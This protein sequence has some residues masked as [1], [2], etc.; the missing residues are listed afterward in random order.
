MMKPIIVVNFKTY[1][2][3]SGKKALKLASV[4]ERVAR[5]SKIIPVVQHADLG[6]VAKKIDLDVYAQHVDYFEPGRNT[7]FST[8][9]SLQNNKVKGSLLNHSEHKLKL[10]IVKKTVKRCKEKNFKVIVCVD[11]LRKTKKILKSQPEMLAFEVP[12]LISTGKS[13]TK[14]KGK[15]VTKFAQIVYK[16]NKKNK[17]KVIPLCG[18]GI[19]NEKDVKAAIKL[20]CSG[21]LVASAVVKSRNPA[22]LLRKMLL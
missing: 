6:F 17:T 18:A 7:G 1:E 13:I 8:I 3:S 9:E 12:E 20:G 16:F 19:S 11:T 15:D 2:K 21:V 14:Y 10:R 4:C 5:T 22:K